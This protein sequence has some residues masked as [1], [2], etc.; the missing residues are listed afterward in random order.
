MFRTRLVIEDTDQPGQW[1]VTA[2]LVWS[3]PTY[4]TLV[5]PA[6]TITDL[7]SIPHQLR[8]FGAFGWYPFD[9]TGP[10]RRPAVGHDYLYAT[11]VWPKDKADR[12]LR[13]ALLAEGVSAGT[14]GAFYWAVR[15]FGGPAWRDSRRAASKAV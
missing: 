13:D 1:R 4:G 5:V 7:A 10:S 9:P 11:G 6:G 14:A 12:F 3:D 2:P 15:L 8:D